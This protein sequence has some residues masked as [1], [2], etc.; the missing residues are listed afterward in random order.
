MAAT[1]LDIPSDKND[2]NSLTESKDHLLSGQDKWGQSNCIRDGTATSESFR[3][4]I[5]MLIL[6][7]SSGM[8]CFF[9][10]SGELDAVLV[11]ITF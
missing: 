5:V 6:A 1:T 8:W 9:H 2:N 4:L 11:K 10:S 7:A 3:F